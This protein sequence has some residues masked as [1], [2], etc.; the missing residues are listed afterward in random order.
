M[1]NYYRDEPD[2]APAADYHAELITNSES[3]KYKISITGKTSNANQENGKNSEQR[4]TK[5]KKKCEI[6]VPLKHLSNFWKR[7]GMP[8]ISCEVFLTLNWSVNCV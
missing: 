5:T 4:N 1:W 2:N 6:V 7:L 3:F 8:L